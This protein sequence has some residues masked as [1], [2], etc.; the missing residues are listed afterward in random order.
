[1]ENEE[2]RDLYNLIMLNNQNNLLSSEQIEI[3]F[4]NLEKAKNVK[5]NLIP[6][7]IINFNNIKEIENLEIK[8]IKWI[9]E[10]NLFSKT[11][12]IIKKLE[13]HDINENNEKNIFNDKRIKINLKNVKI[14]NIEIKNTK[15]KNFD[16]SYTKKYCWKE[17]ERIIEKKYPNL[18]NYIN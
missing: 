15:I 14:K 12:W 18:I 17:A 8:K 13:I 9:K 11:N 3:N 5:V 7:Y 10:I 2:R 16:K 6:N 4:N 1:M